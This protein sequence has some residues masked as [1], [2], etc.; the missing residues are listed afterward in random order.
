MLKLVGDGL[1]EH[2]QGVAV[3]VGPAALV[4]AEHAQRAENLARRIGE[5]H[6]EVGP[7]LPRRDGRQVVDP[8]MTRGVL[9]REGLSQ[10]DGDR[11]HAVSCRCAL[12]EVPVD[13]NGSGDHLLATGQ[14]AH[15][16]ARRAEKLRGDRSQP[17][18]HA[19]L[20]AGRQ[21]TLDRSDPRRI[22]ENGK[23][24]PRRTGGWLRHPATVTVLARKRARSGNLHA[25][26]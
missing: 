11:A 12:A 22:V 19:G 5:D 18:N 17:L 7:D 10:G 26:A 21:N 8:R 4:C 16:S 2:A 23:T 14:Q 13:T 15:L 6:A 20:A 25:A 1:C 9:D 24:R 3:V